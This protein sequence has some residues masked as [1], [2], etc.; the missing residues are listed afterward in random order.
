[1]SLVNEQNRYRIVHR[2]IHVSEIGLFSALQGYDRADG[3]PSGGGI[4]MRT[5]SGSDYRQVSMSVAVGPM[6]EREYL[7]VLDKSGNSW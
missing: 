4:G 7:P 2:R 6:F 5:G 3:Q 1:M